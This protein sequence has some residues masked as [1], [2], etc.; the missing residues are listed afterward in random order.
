MIVRWGLGELVAVLEELSV[1]NA[2]LVTTPRWAS[3]DLPVADRFDGVQPHSA[4]E[5]VHA[6]VAAAE[7]HDGLVVMGG[8]SAID[9]AKA[10]SAA[11]GLPLVAIPTTYG[12][13][14]WTRHFG[15][16]DRASGVKIGGSGN[17]TR[18]IVY[19]PELTLG[20]PWAESCGTAM[21]AL[22]HCIEGLLFGECEDCWIGAR[23]IDEWLPRVNAN[24]HDLRARRNLLRGAEHA[25][26]ALATMGMGVGHAMAQ[27][28]GGRYLLPHGA[29]SA[30][31]L[32]PAMRFNG[33]DAPLAVER[34]Q[35]FAALGGFHRLRDFGVP[36]AELELVSVAAAERGPAKAN[37][38]QATPEAIATLLLDA[39]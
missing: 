25:G 20:L 22:A 7:G 5:G 6:A 21:N 33:V 9:T 17:D 23:L 4:L 31:C 12:G 35:E 38:R 1:T 36:R 16:R 14:E 39:W 27:A 18:A 11:T 37:P 8:G 24:P 34:V 32:P 29:M 10:V 15:T 26:R 2:L 13:A 28:L 30:I 3:H 19:E